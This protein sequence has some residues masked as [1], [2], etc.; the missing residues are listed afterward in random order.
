MFHNKTLIT[1]VASFLYYV[2]KYHSLCIK[3]RNGSGTLENRFLTLGLFGTT[4]GRERGGILMER[5]E[6]DGRRG[7]LI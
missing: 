7:I 3:D 1:K 5:R 4:K 2:P 6:R